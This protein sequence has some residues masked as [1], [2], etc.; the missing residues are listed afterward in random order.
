[1]MRALL[2]VLLM[3]AV[4]GIAAHAQNALSP[5]QERA[6]R[7]VLRQELKEHPEL[8]LDAIRQLQAR[9]RQA[10][11]DRHRDLIRLHED[12]MAAD[13][14]DFVAGNPKGDVTLVEFFDYR[15]PYCKAM[16]EPLQALVKKDGKLRLVLKEFPILGPNSTLA[17]K[18][19]IGARPQGRYLAFHEALLTHKGDLDDKAVTAIARGLGIDTGKMKARAE[20]PQVTAK[21]A[22]NLDL[23]RALELDGTPAFIIG[24]TL[25]PGA[26]DLE[27]LEQA[28]AEARKKS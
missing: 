26:V 19:S 15:C 21:L 10:N 27:M 2:L 7:D 20:D 12:E 9:D 16:A 23:G 24:D 13:S 6:V 22:R 5:E 25:I 1:M 3:L 11:E 14:E 28:I 17:S 18:A 8:V 4:S